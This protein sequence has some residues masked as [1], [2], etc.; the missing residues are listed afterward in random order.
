METAGVLL[1]LAI[2]TL[3]FWILIFLVTFVPY[4]VTLLILDKVNPE[5]ANKLAGGDKKDDDDCGC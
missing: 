2:M 1:F 3:V 5:L 4:M